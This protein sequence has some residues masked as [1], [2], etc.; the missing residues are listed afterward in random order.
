MKLISTKRFEKSLRKLSSDQEERVQHALHLFT[1]N[2][3]NEALRNH[4]LHGKW[5]R[6]RSISAGFDVRII[7]QEKNNHA[8]VI[9]VKAG[10]HNQVY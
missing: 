6:M 1:E 3:F 4:A 7:Y 5:K 9:L 10:T 2:P 8:I